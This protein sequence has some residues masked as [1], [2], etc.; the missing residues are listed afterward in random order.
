MATTATTIHNQE[1][2]SVICYLSQ[3]DLASRWGMSIRTLERWR[4][5]GQG[6]CYLKLGTRVLYHPDDI[7][8]FEQ[9]HRH[10]PVLTKACD[11][12]QNLKQEKT[13]NLNEKKI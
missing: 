7:R 12:R 3:H 10:Q 5:F 9:L 2:S 1:N 13:D 11:C 4:F 6:P 8:E